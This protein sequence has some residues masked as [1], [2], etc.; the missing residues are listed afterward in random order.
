M[1]DKRS[2]RRF[3]WLFWIG[4]AV[5]IGAALALVCGAVIWSGYERRAATPLPT[6]PSL[7]PSSTAGASVEVRRAAPV[8]AVPARPAEAAQVEQSDG[9]R[10]QKMIIRV[11]PVRR[12]EAADPEEVE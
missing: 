10:T 11:V 5:A 12:A 6:P 4:L 8:E 2:R 3:R 9:Q 1:E 7:A